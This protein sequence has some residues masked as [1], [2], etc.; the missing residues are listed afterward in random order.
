MVDFIENMDLK[1]IEFVYRYLHN[2]VVDF[3]MIAFTYAGELGIVWIACIIFLSFQKRHWKTTILMAVSLIFTA[4]IV[5]GVLKIIFSRPRPFEALAYITLLIP[6]PP[7]HS[8]PSGHSS[9]SFAAAAMILLCSRKH[10]L[11]V[12]A[13]CFALLISF[14][15]LYLA[16]HYPSDILAGA[17]IGT[18]CSL[19][20][21]YGDRW[22][23][24]KR[25]GT[26]E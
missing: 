10:I 12:V 23:G 6:P 18:A 14:S 25:T 20:V 11:S 7:G 4:I 19:L 1:A 3:I 5:N 26:E 2:P 16:V 21:F 15:R 9:S 17:L 24:S 13:V 8:F 22:L